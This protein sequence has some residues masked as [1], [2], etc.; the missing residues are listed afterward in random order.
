MEQLQLILISLMPAL[1]TL[2]AILLVAWK[3]VSQFK[4][5]RSEV[6][7]DKTINAILADN[8]RL[9][10]MYRQTLDKIDELESKIETLAMTNQELTSSINRMNRGE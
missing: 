10:A 8:K 2:L 5:L 9:N 1:G 7:D 6:K 4:G 3:I